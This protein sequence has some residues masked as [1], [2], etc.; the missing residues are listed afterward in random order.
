M[1]VIEHLFALMLNIDEIAITH[2]VI[3]TGN[4]SCYDNV[5][6]RDMT[7]SAEFVRKK[8]T[9]IATFQN[10]LMHPS[11]SHFTLSSK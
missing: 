7:N 1:S 11:I 6:M 2:M 10:G 8:H 3:P 5:G 4:L 9:G